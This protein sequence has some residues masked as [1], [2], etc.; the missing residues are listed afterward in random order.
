[1]TGDPLSAR[2]L[3]QLRQ[4][5]EKEQS[6]LAVFLFGSHVQGYATERSDIDLGLLLARTPDLQ[7]RLALEVLLCQALGREDVDFLLLAEAPLQLRFRAISGQVLYERSPDLVS[8]FMQRTMVA[9]YDFLHVLKTY[10]R[11]FAKSLEKDYG[12]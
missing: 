2:Q 3:K 8:D 7:D 6:L 12:L 5:C 9:Y 10:E 4:V 11:E 1:V